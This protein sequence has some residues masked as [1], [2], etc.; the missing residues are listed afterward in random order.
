MKNQRRALLG[1]MVTGVAIAAIGG[2]SMTANAAQ[3]TSNPPSVVQTTADASEHVRPTSGSDNG[4][5]PWRYNATY[6]RG[7]IV[8]LGT[9][10]YQSMQDNNVHHLPLD[11][12]WWM[13][14]GPAK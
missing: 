10:E 5:L 7:V 1:I 12:Y 3:P 13:P 14:V 9:I 4:Y 8:T 11:R 2:V 6:S